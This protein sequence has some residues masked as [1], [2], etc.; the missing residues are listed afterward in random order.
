MNYDRGVKDKMP[1]NQ[2]FKWKDYT[3][4]VLSSS[5]LRRF[6]SI[7]PYF[8]SETI[9]YNVKLTRHKKTFD[10]RLTYEWQLTNSIDKT[11]VDNHGG[12]GEIIVPRF[13]P[14]NLK[15]QGISLGEIEK[16]QYK[17][18]LMV[19]NGLETS[20]FT[21]I[22]EVTVKSDEVENRIVWIAGGTAIIASIA[23]IVLIF[24]K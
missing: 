22:L 2:D 24:M 16:G 20:P 1:T 9:Y 7:L 15:K 6:L 19:G 21:D 3:I 4:S 17:V 10:K 12:K 5:S 8:P 18:Q 23:A 13:N 11:V 14:N